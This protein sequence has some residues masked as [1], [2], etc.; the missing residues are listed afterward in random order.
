MSAAEWQNSPAAATSDH[1]TPLSIHIETPAKDR[2][3]CRRIAVSEAAGPARCQR[4]ERSGDVGQLRR[5]RVSLQLQ[6]GFYIG[7]AAVSRDV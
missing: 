5:T 7:C 1:R 2:G 4:L 3:R 6:W